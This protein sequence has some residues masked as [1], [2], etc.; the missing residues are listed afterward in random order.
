MNTQRKNFEC[1]FVAQ[2]RLGGEYMLSENLKKYR[3]EQRYS[4]QKLAEE[5]GC[6]ATLIQLIET[7]ENDN[8]GLKTL[9]NISKALKIPL[10]KLLK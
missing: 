3:K 2:K 9:M 8:P 5:A 6:S 10:V 7:G 4:R 1:F